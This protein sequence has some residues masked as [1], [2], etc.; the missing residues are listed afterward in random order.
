MKKVTILFLSFLLFLTAFSIDANEHTYTIGVITFLSTETQAVFEDAKK[1]LEENLEYGNVLFI[2]AATEATCDEYV[3]L[4]LS[5]NATDNVYK[6]TY[7]DG[8]YL[9]SSIYS[10]EGYKSY[11]TFLMEIIYYPLEKL[12]IH[13]L[14][15]KDFSGYLRLTYYPGVDEYGDYSNGLFLFITD[16][17]AGN[18]NIAYIDIF[19]N[20]IKLLP[21][22][23]SSEYYPK[24][25]PNSESI[26]F[27]GS[28]H[29]F[30]NIYV[31]P[32]GDPNYSRKIKRI[33]KG[34]FPAY[35]PEWYDE[36]TVLYIQD[37]ETGNVM[38]KKNIKTGQIQKVNTVGAMVFTPKVFN[39]EIYYTSLQ[40]ANFGIYKNVDGENYKV[41]DTFYNEHDPVIIDA[42]HMIFTSNRDGLYRIWMKNLETGSVTCL[43]PD[44]NYDVFYPA[45]G[46][47]I[48]FFSVY[49]EGQ[50]PDIY[51]LKLNLDD[52]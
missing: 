35:S 1:V 34:N 29:G 25:S 43:T 11:K 7:E 41:E 49:E 42:T 8:D 16:R 10:P 9:V 38:I 17:L 46:D 5:Y 14:K 47:G 51:A 48:L 33:S 45:Y 3:N 39:T 2:N 15:T 4:Y 28:L 20:K 19:S 31:M 44:L 21:V 37:T 22:F 30:W 12:A 52:M 27:Q 13:R 40:G 18:R 36:N 32:F 50:E 6:A 24:F 26:L 23:G